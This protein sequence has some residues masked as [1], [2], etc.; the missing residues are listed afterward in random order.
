MSSSDTLIIGLS[1]SSFDINGKAAVLA[2]M[3]KVSLEI[4]AIA[5]GSIIALIQTWALST[6]GASSGIA[7]TSTDTDSGRRYSATLEGYEGEAELE[8][9]KVSDGLMIAAH[10]GVPPSM[11]GMG[12][13]RAIVERLIADAR[14]ESFRILPLCPFVKALYRKHPQ[15]IDVMKE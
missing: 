10:T 8:L 6:C 13:G 12:V 2:L 4:C 7:I 1:V 9:S 5:S 15:W 3:K 11:E 14:A